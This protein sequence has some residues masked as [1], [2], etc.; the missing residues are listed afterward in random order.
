[1]QLKAVGISS[2]DAKLIIGTDRICYS[3]VIGNNF[4]YPTV[5][6]SYNSLTVNEQKSSPNIRG[7]NRPAGAKNN[8]SYCDGLPANRL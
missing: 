6:F 4:F 5:T 8:K 2:I 7:Y 1:M 3:I